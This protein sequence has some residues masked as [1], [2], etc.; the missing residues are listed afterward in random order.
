MSCCLYVSNAIDASL[1]HQLMS[2]GWMHTDTG[3]DTKGSA[4]R[5][6]ID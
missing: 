3:K 2:H 6:R 5:G 4:T 1:L